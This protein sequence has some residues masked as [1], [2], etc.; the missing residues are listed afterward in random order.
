MPTHYLSWS[1]ISFPLYSSPLQDLLQTDLSNCYC[2]NI[3]WS[4][5]KAQWESMPFYLKV[6]YELCSPCIFSWWGPEHLTAY[7]NWLSFELCQT[8]EQPWFT[9]SP[10]TTDLM[11]AKEIERQPSVTADIKGECHTLIQA[12][13]YLPGQT[14]YRD[15]PE[16]S[17]EQTHTGTQNPTTQIWKWK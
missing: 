9:W 17:K 8:A 1:T 16:N 14:Y 15:H 10:T 4:L 13:L 7:L 12:S 2:I 3:P 6:C 5:L 11:A